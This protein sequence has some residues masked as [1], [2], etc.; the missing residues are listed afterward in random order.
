MIVDDVA[1]VL[2]AWISCGEASKLTRTLFFFLGWPSSDGASDVSLGALAPVGEALVI[3][4]EVRT[5][6]A[7]DAEFF[8]ADLTGLTPL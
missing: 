8:I 6:D 1:G 7:G 5:E 2:G 3:G 4:E